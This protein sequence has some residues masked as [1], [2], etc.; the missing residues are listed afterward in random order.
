[1]LLEARRY[2]AEEKKTLAAKGQVI[3]DLT[4]MLLRS[5]RV[6]GRVVVAE[7]AVTPTILK[8]LARRTALIVVGQRGLS[9]FERYLLGSVSSSIAL[10]ASCSVLIVKQQF[11]GIRRILLATDGSKSS[12]NA[13]RFLVKNLKPP[14]QSN[15]KAAIRVVLLHVAPGGPAS[16]QRGR[17]YVERYAAQLGKAGYGVRRLVP[18]GVPGDEILKAADAS[19]AELLIVG[20]TGLTGI[21]RL[22]LGSVSTKVVLYSKCSVLV[23]R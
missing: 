20:A 2:I 6:Q 3:R 22:L 9:R 1:M 15:G 8:S 13:L 21:K 5:L 7:G 17:W 19:R 14:S 23:V 12:D 18:T 10:H 4:E 11:R 16:L